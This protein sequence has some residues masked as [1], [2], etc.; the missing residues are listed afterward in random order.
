M[1]P[2]RPRCGWPMHPRRNHADRP[3]QD[4]ILPRS[5]GGTDVLHGDTRNTVIMCQGC[6]ERRGKCFHCWAVVACVKDVARSELTDFW[7]VWRAWGLN[8]QQQAAVPSERT[9]LAMV[10]RIGLD[11]FVYPA[12]TAAKRVWNL[13]SLMRG[14][15]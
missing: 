2:A 7:T 3:S 10:E 1:T 5:R 13:A 12:D 6:N 4:H 14:P 11:E 8:H 9:T 15:R